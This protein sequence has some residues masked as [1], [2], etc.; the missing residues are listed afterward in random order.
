MAL[1]IFAVAF[2]KRSLPPYTTVRWRGTVR[3]GAFATKARKS[4]V[5]ETSFVGALVRES[6]DRVRRT[7]LRAHRCCKVVACTVPRSRNF[8]DCLNDLAQNV[9]VFILGV[10]PNK[11]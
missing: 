10:L 8:S 3:C 6:T 2:E 9:R 4:M 11:T 7:S 5:V 1:G